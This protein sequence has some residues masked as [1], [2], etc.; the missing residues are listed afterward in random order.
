MSSES[1]LRAELLPD[2]AD[3]TD[4]TLLTLSDLDTGGESGLRTGDTRRERSGTVVAGSRVKGS[5][6]P[7]EVH[8]NHTS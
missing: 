6:K 5:V 8:I 3:D 4:D 2:D 1:A 7:S